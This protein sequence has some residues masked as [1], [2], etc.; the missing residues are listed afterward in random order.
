MAFDDNIRF[1]VVV[2]G[3]EAIKN[4][5]VSL[6]NLIATNKGLTNQTRSMDSAQRAL[7]R[8][9]GVTSK[10]MGEHAK[11]IRQ[12]IINQKALG[13]EIHRVQAEARRVTE[14]VKHLNNEL[15][16]K[17]A[18]QFASGMRGV[19]SSL[20][21]IKARALVSDLKSVSLQ[22]KKMGKDA[23]F[24][25]RSLIIGL[26]TPMLL[27][28]RR[29]VDSLKT[30]SREF[31]RM[32]KILSKD[33]TDMAQDADSLAAKFN[34]FGS[35]I[36]IGSGGATTGVKAL[37]NA[38]Y[39]LSN[40][41][42]ISRDL[43]TGVTAD[44]AE[45]GIQSEGVLAGLTKV[46][47]EMS[48][49]GS[50]DVSDSQL[51][52]QTMFL[53][54]IRTM[55]LMGRTFE[56][57]ADKQAAALASVNAQLALFNRI[58]NN[59]ALSFRDMADSLP[60]A[61]A[62]ATSFGLS[63]TQ[64][65]SLL[66]P[67][68]AAGIDIST[69][70]NGLKVSFQRLV[71]PTNQVNQTMASLVDTYGTA[72]PQ[73]ESAFEAIQGVGMS[74]IQGLID[75]T[76]S[77]REETTVT[78]EELLNFYSHLFRK[79]QAPRMLV[80]IDD[81]VTFQ[82]ELKDTGGPVGAFRNELNMAIREANRATGGIVPLVDTVEDLTQVSKLANSQVN[83]YSKSLG[84][85]VT[86]ADIDSA[87]RTR[88][89]ILEEYRTMSED[90]QDKIEQLLSEV[91]SQAGKG[92]VTE[93]LGAGSAQQAANDELGKA[94]GA[95]YTQ[96]DRIKNSFK[97]LAIEFAEAFGE[98]FKT[99]ADSFQGL[100]DRVRNLSKG[101]RKFI[102]IILGAVAALGPLVFIFGQFRLAIGVVMGGLLKLLPSMV[103]LE[104]HSLAA[105]P[106]MLRLRRS[107]VMVG[108]GFSTSAGR[109]SRFIA[110]M[111]S[112]KGPIASM[113]NQFGMMTGILKT[114]TTADAGVMARMAGTTGPGQ[115]IADSI[116][117]SANK[118]VLAQQKAAAAQASSVVNAGNTAAAAISGAGNNVA[119]KL[120]A[121]Q[122]SSLKNLGMGSA[123]TL[124]GKSVVG[125][126]IKPGMSL[127]VGAPPSIVSMPVPPVSTKTATLG[128]KPIVSTGHKP[129]MSLPIG[130]RPTSTYREVSQVAAKNLRGLGYDVPMT[131]TGAFSGR[132]GALATTVGP[133]AGRLNRPA[134]DEAAAMA[135]GRIL[136]DRAHAFGLSP[137]GVG[138]QDV[139]S[140]RFL[141]GQV[142]G[143]AVS[144]SRKGL[145]QGS[146]FLTG[147][148]AK[149]RDKAA[150]MS[151]AGQATRL[152]G[153]ATRASAL[154]GMMQGI[155][156]ANAPVPDYTSALGMTPF[157]R[158]QIG[159]ED[160]TSASRFGS[161]RM[162]KFRAIRSG[163]G[164]SIMSFGQTMKGA[165]QSAVAGAMRGGA[166]SLG[167]AAR[168]AR[169]AAAT[170]A[171]RPK[172]LQRAMMGGS[173]LAGLFGRKGVDGQALADQARFRRTGFLAQ[174]GLGIDEAT[175]RATGRGGRRLG[176]MEE[177]MVIRRGRTAAGEGLL[178]KS[179]LA[180]TV[181]GAD[182]GSI[183]QSFS[184]TGMADTA[185][186]V[187]RK[188]GDYSGTTKSL[189]P[190]SA[191]LDKANAKQ[192][193]L[194]EKAALFNKKSPSSFRRGA[195]SA[196]IY[197]G[198]VGNSTLRML[199]GNKAVDAMSAKMKAL[200]TTSLLTFSGMKTGAISAIKS[201]TSLG[202][203]MKIARTAL[204]GAGIGIALLAIAG[205]AAVVVGHF[206]KFKEKTQPAM[207]ALKNTLETLK[208]IGLA[209]VEPFL[210]F[211]QIFAAG[212]ESTSSVEG[213]AN[214][215]NTI[216]Q[217]IQKAADKVQ[218]FVEQYVVPFI[219]KALG[220]VMTIIDG[221]KMIVKGAQGMRSGAQ[222]SFDQLKAGVGKVFE[223]IK[224]LFL[225]TLA[226]ALVSGIAELIK[227]MYRIF[228]KLV[229]FMPQIIVGIIRLFI[230]FRILAF[231]IIRFLVVGIMRLFA[232]M[233]EFLS[234]VFQEM[235]KMAVEFARKAL[236][237]LGWLGDI[238]GFVAGPILDG[239]N[240][241]G[242]GVAAMGAAAS[243]ALNVLVD[244]AD[245][246]MGGLLSLA[247]A[248]T[249]FLGDKAM[250]LAGMLSDVV[251]NALAGTTEGFD[252][253]IDGFKDMALQALEQFAPTEVGKNGGK[254]LGSQIADAAS[255]ALEEEADEI[256]EP[257]I[258]ASSAAGEDA[259]NEFA[260]KFK[261]QMDDLRQK[262][263]D[264]VGD[265]LGNEISKVADEL[266][267]ALE[268]QRDAA[269]AVFDE[270]IDVLD[271][272]EDAEK[273]LTAER[274][275]Q[276]TLRKL[277][278]ERELNAANYKRNR[279]LAIYEGRIDDAR[280]LDREEQKDQKDSAS[281]IADTQNK[282]NEQLRKENLNFLK[283]SIKEAKKE[284]DDFF[285]AQIAAFKES[286]KDITK[287]APQTIED[288]ESQLTQ[289]K[290]L[291]T[292]FGEENAAEFAKTF[293]KMQEKI[294]TEMP[295]KTV[296]V[297]GTNLD[298]LINT[299]RAKFGLDNN[300]IGV[301]GATVDLLTKMGDKFDPEGVEGQA[302]STNFTNI[303][304]SL[305]DEI[306]S[307]A[308]DGIKA[309]I[310]KHGP[311]AVLEAA[312]KHANE[313]ILYEWTGTVD[314]IISKVDD[315]ADMMDPYIAAVV[316]AQLAWEAVQEAIEGANEA[317]GSGG[318]SDGGPTTP[319]PPATAQNKFPW[320]EYFKNPY[321]G[322]DVSIVVN[323]SLAEI[324]SPKTLLPKD[325][326]PLKP[327]D[328]GY[329][330]KGGIVRGFAKGGRIPSFAPGGIMTPGYRS[331]GIPA[332]LH[333]GEYVLNRQAVQKI[334]M[335][336]SMLDMLN[337]ARFGGANLSG[338]PYFPDKISA[339]KPKT[340]E[341]IVNNYNTTNTTHIYVENFI[342]E[343]EWF[344][345]MIKEYNM[346][347]RPAQDKKF[348]TQ[349]RFY[350]T[351]K[352]AGMY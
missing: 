108:D 271:K 169:G 16:R 87:R 189:G 332:I 167:G 130:P 109:F 221:F 92:L 204:M 106:A 51:L 15:E 138:A 348:N 308:S 22:M 346:K 277:Q 90:G 112:G 34:N 58:E 3:E 244:V 212:E 53:G 164:G 202:N 63:M 286:S 146:A 293:D 73:L 188:L 304:E 301:V 105:A 59:T 270:Q 4:L 341:G 234:S 84:R 96:I 36:K 235:L 145:F 184:K 283:N 260:K 292:V 230:E 135:R 2:D 319:V 257:I 263:V 331:T 114:G 118:V 179:R 28:A 94:L 333:G 143:G 236:D 223:G 272:L 43:L 183:K 25:G 27:F 303:L 279:A 69:A 351:Y 295:E 24:V 310:E 240:A 162:G 71:T 269:L 300:N 99:L 45:L 159:A 123:A 48:I 242:S 180:R 165:G 306:K 151:A 185:R 54:T 259:G 10:G 55:N 131:A 206:D 343:D 237:S 190:L 268:A 211:F 251:G 229:E 129:G 262:F 266:T 80:V 352:G 318:G 72:A 89:I 255:E 110:T 149:I 313:S 241:I 70:A 122:T 171:P 111:A 217:F 181:A 232:K 35:A 152:G 127:P 329:W 155:V 121:K 102:V 344:N 238:V 253:M 276:L 305:S 287:F 83:D 298:T 31:T 228:I 170:M 261:D 168:T 52:T 335:T 68:K 46:T 141:T 280:L 14:T 265:Y 32:S 61:S 116:Y 274:E 201:I 115:K 161:G 323:S 175:G 249:D 132:A 209:L 12:V 214:A 104:A 207:E 340:P 5:S 336:A 64:T 113:A 321:Q 142:R 93:F 264:L 120:T 248:A 101:T 150:S 302:I 17:G 49:L 7:S 42:G 307:E 311:A 275:H 193:A 81:L 196:K 11:S 191:A 97:N 227:V 224:Q 140:E 148:A 136:T 75:A 173:S 178:G 337:K 258:D 215:F 282:R 30:Y 74:S 85:A 288:Y 29:G 62:A 119:K 26:T 166:A 256:Y 56:S 213:I 231:K 309:V 82:K 117:A 317:A 222:G 314:H 197:S 243:S 200:R 328:A 291:A 199:I 338:L 195:A 324:V 44:F 330:S 19:A 79:R 156:A 33:M 334:G 210:D 98:T 41:T 107:V 86:Q 327:G 126:G 186:G 176:R 320:D 158:G 20:R 13:S 247:D 134:M 67:M 133:M 137:M 50:M 163:V 172:D 284:A 37:E 347:V 18:R 326:A 9:I 233:P 218:A 100:L 350:T 281:T 144:K 312:I 147:Q 342:G 95:T 289:L 76:M 60:E 315:L 88:E 349:D 252:S 57:N 299:A 239:I 219:R 124:G 192:A 154:G 78:D 225:G 21:G 322:A 325:F 273:S 6:R 8:S 77:L 254:A 91:S 47:T 66:A 245:V 187:G 250:D 208:N 203:A 246:A 345:S 65:A 339:P 139:R 294:V 198:A 157:E 220:A 38:L 39:E 160:Y 285:K 23:Q 177:N 182:I 297:F 290:D 1:N 205:I 153:A 296:G 40:Q 174:R 194:T 267:S 125:A 226:P 103:A 216:A 316:Q 128:G 278:D